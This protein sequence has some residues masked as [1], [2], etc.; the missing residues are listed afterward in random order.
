MTSRNRRAV[1]LKTKPI[2]NNCPGKTYKWQASFPARSI[3]GEDLF[4]WQILSVCQNCDMT[5]YIGGFPLPT[6][7]DERGFEDKYHPHEPV[8]N[9]KL[10]AV[11]CTFS[12]IKNNFL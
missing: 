7:V 2:E 11:H 6:G 9:L 8:E 4:F 3:K 5:S 1:R 12:L 10:N